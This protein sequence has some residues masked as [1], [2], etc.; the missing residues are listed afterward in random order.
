MSTFDVKGFRHEQ[1]SNKQGE[2]GLGAITTA[3]IL[4]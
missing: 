3:Q 2:L 1:T 4:V